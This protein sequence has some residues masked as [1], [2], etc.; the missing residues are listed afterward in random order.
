MIVLFHANELKNLV[1]KW[2]SK[3]AGLF[4]DSKTNINS[5]SWSMSKSLNGFRLLKIGNVWQDKVWY[6]VILT[7]FAVI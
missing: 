2:L 6:E 4:I 1:K 5:R 7:A 3:K